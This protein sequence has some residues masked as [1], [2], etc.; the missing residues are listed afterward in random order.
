MGFGR[1][2]IKNKNCSWYLPGH[3]SFAQGPRGVGLPLQAPFYKALR[4]IFGRGLYAIR[5]SGR[6]RAWWP[7]V[8]PFCFLLA[9]AWLPGAGRVDN[10]NYPQWARPSIVD[11]LDNLKTNCPQCPQIQKDSGKRKR[12]GA[13]KLGNCG[14]VGQCGQPVLSRWLITFAQV[15]I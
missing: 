7:G 15:I 8:F 4:A 11:K 14:Q 13:E 6:A 5:L 3:N 1:V 9:G 12:A 10:L 2:A